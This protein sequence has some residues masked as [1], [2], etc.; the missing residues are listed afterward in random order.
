[1]KKDLT[2]YAFI[3]SQNI[4]LGIQELGWKLDWKE[5]RR[6]LTE[7][8]AVATAY[9]F[10]GHI[11]Q[12]QNLYRM[13]QEAGFVLIFKPVFTP[14]DGSKPKGN[15]DADLV[16]QAMIQYD[17]YEKAVIVTSDGDFYCLVEYLKSKGKLE[18]VLCA[19]RKKSSVL[20][21]RA[22]GDKI[23]FLEYSQRALEYK[24]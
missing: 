3:D 15:V 6:H 17:N 21:R 2:N 22:A 16:L 13:L 20:L 19:S 7:K 23:A 1:M 12:N 9:L 5:F 4:N 10:I 8:Y 11:A 24:K 18:R 14:R